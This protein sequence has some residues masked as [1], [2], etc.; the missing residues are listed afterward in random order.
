MRHWK[1]ALVRASMGGQIATQIAAAGSRA[2]GIVLL[3]YPLHPPGKPEKM[4]RENLPEISV[5]MLFLRGSRDSLR[6]LDDLADVCA[7]WVGR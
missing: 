3:G 7:D 4:C 1:F 5:P 2:D 6:N